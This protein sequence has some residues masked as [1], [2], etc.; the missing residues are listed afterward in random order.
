MLGMR[1]IRSRLVLLV[2]GVALLVSG[3]SAAYNL[4]R[5][6]VMLREEMVKRGGSI[7][8][9]LAYN[10]K[11]GVLTEDKL[12]L[13][14]LLEGAMRSGGG[15]ASDVV[16]AMIRDAKGGVLAQ[17]G[18]SIK[19]L[20]AAPATEDGMLETETSAGDPVILFRA[21]VTTPSGGGD[22]SAELGLAPSGE[23]RGRKEDAK[24]GVE[25]AISRSPMNKQQRVRFLET[26]GLSF[27]LLSLGALAGWVLVG[28]W[29]APVQHMVE[30]SS[31]V[32]KGDL[33]EELKIESDDEIGVLA[34][35]LSEMV[36]NLRRIVDN[37]QEASVQVASSAGQISANARLITQGAQSQA[38][39]AEETS[40]SMEEMAAS[41][42]TVAANSQSLATYV[43][44]TSSSITEMGAS[45][46]QVAKSSGSLA[47]TVT[48]A[49][50]TI[51]QMTVSID[52]MAKNLESLAE[53]VAETS[54]TVE[55]MT[56]F[57]ASVAQNA[58]T[59]GQAAQRTS[60]TVSGMAS[61]VNDVAKIAEEAD[62]ISAR[63]S[64][65]ARTGGEA[66][67]RTIQGMKTISENMENTARV[68]TGLGRR[69]QEI[70]KI[71]E[72]IEEIADQT[73]LLALN[74]AIEA[75]R[76]GE[77]G[78]G[79]AVVADEVRKLAERS[80]EATKEIGEVIR[81][82]Q[83]DTGEAVEAAKAGALETKEGIALA[84][85]AGAALRNI[86][87]SVSRSTQLM[88]QI[89]QATAKQSTASA[90]VRETVANMNTATDQVTSAV[91][92]QA[93]GSKQIRQ[94]ME[95]I[96]RIM[97]QAAYSTK[98]QAAGGRQVRVAV[99]DMNR[100]AAQVGIATKEQAEGSR[101]I[102]HAVEKMNDMTQAVSHATAEQ[103]KGG[104]L[105]V[106]AME[107][108]SEIA[109]DNLGTVEE[110]SK[111]TQNLAQ[112][113]ENL[114]KLISVFRLQ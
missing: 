83:Q 58:E 5:S 78:R 40:T 70:G 114:A 39:A 44:E 35:S 61:A 102:V 41:I 45:I 21:A 53:T 67:A 99:E 20:P 34:K 65:D 73:N 48:E 107:N 11:Y 16:G 24:G 100:I 8:S 101:Q 25:V 80:V 104:E 82:V 1:S 94:A 52:Q 55:E 74:A 27:G 9:N 108:I 97:T 109:R 46:E 88:A 57:I 96:R 54:G 90:E 31:A 56:T 10:S 49:S 37:I 63:A 14:E 22:M 64:E 79:F 62:R 28:R 42:Q 32:A 103:K 95:N 112:Q 59:L 69:S 51:E 106:R 43:E 29:F 113:A 26:A 75:A 50:A 4:Y 6:R 60:L 3:L 13:M 110:M 76:A 89:A 7:A 30:V 85:K 66:V 2:G 71:L 36:G 17:K 68:I 93:E 84:D 77:A 38:Q 91:R 33:T 86:I 72:V 87:E 19:E 12:Q 18:A 23:A 111:A 98:E 47:Q 105:V 81:Q 92:E 15:E